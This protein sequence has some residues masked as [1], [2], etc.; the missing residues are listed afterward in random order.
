MKYAVVRIGGKQYRVSE[1]ERLT[2]DHIPEAASQQSFTDVLLYVEDGK[3]R[4]GTPRIEDFSV[5]AHVLGEKKGEKVRVSQFKAKA[6][7]RRTIGF[8][9]LYTEVAIASIGPR[10]KTARKTK[11]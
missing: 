11:E 7:H 5:S 1:G 10:T 9:P 3:V 4:V 6:R 2:V 8:R